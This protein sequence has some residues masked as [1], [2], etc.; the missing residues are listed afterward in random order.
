[1]FMPKATV[2]LAIASLLV[3]PTLL[4]CRGDK[5]DASGA[6]DAV[7]A[8]LVGTVGEQ[9]VLLAGGL[10]VRGYC[11]VV[12]LG[13]KGSA[14]VPPP[15]RKYLSRYIAR[16]GIG[17]ASQ[18]TGGVSV[19]R[20]L[21]DPDTAVVEIH[22]V[23]P[24]GA[25]KG[26]HFDVGVRALEQTQTESLD[27]GT[28]M[29]TEMAVSQGPFIRPEGQLNIWANA[30]GTVFINPFGDDDEGAFD[31]ARMRMGRVLGGGVVTRS[32]NIVLKLRRPNYQQA[33]LIQ[34]RIN[35]RFPGVHKV[36][37][38]A[39]AR[40]PEVVELTIPSAYGR[41]YLHFLSLVMHLS[42]HSGP[43]ASE[44]HAQRL[45]H[46]MAQP[47]ASYEDLALS[48]EAMGRQVVELLRGNYASANPAVSYFSARTGVRLGDDLAADVL[49]RFA[50]S[51]NSP[52]RLAA[53]RELGR[54]SGILRA[55]GTLKR[56][57]DDPNEMVRLAAYEALA[58]RGGSAAIR[59]IRI[60]K[61][62]DV[63]LV[64]SSRDYVVYATRTQR[65]RLVL[66]GQNMP[67][68]RPMFY[69]APDDL[70]TL[71]ARAD[72][73]Q[74][75]LFRKV[76]R[77]GRYVARFTGDT[78]RLRRDERMQAIRDQAARNA[79]LGMVLSLAAAIV[80][81]GLI[82]PGDVPVA[83]LSLILALGTLIYG[84]SD[85]WLRRP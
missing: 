40:N 37:K 32:R 13:T 53:I 63:D 51:A 36:D 14:E 69:N 11:V 55:V 61:Q 71:S 33:D 58:Q 85:Y 47:G 8:H 72:A 10:P 15:L 70:V 49:I 76:P 34:K 35:Q 42:L 64:Q 1:M 25:P 4:G 29:P 31:R 83:V 21:S 6:A 39:N 57:L 16:Q 3:L 7:P 75:S 74:L 79:L 30:A 24:A 5:L 73:K 68:S 12:G 46:A 65:P 66:F 20:F 50:D 23:V 54:H 2:P 19:A 48:L 17:W 38:V 22:G 26:T 56:L 18:G 84:V 80:V 59:R 67:I 60:P 9:A 52:H 44:A 27:G 77:S 78:A 45:V 62:F 28:L 41:D 43:G 81:Y 82:L